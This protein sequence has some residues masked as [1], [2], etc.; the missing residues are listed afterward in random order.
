MIATSRAQTDATAAARSAPA[1]ASPR[2]FG[3]PS[4]ATT[5]ANP[6]ASAASVTISYG[7]A[8]VRSTFA[9]ERSAMNAA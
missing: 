1:A 6:A 8:T 7:T 2:T 3:F 9:A 4:S 5:A